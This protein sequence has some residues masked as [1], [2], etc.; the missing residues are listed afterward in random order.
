ME[1]VTLDHA[2]IELE[3]QFA[4]YKD[5]S[6]RRIALQERISRAEDQR[7][8][9]KDK[10]FQ[11]VLRGY[12]NDLQAVEQDL[13]PLQKK[14][15]EARADLK[16]R[17]TDI[18]LQTADL[19]DQLDELA[20]RHRVGEFD[21]VE[22][23]EKQAP[24]EAEYEELTQRGIDYVQMLEKLETL[25]EKKPLPADENEAP[26]DVDTSSPKEDPAAPEDTDTSSP[27][28]ESAAP[29]NTEFTSVAF[30]AAETT[31]TEVA[32]VNPGAPPAL[33]D[34]PASSTS[35]TIEIEHNT[36]GEPLV[37]PSTWAGELADE[38]FLRA[39]ESKGADVE[40]KTEEE[41]P[42]KTAEQATPDILGYTELD[43][44]EDSDASDPLSQLADPS[45]DETQRP[46]E[47]DSLLETDQLE[48]SGTTGQPGDGFPVLS[49]ISGAGAGK[50]LPLLPMTM[51]IGRELDNNIELKDQDVARYHAR[52]TYHAGEYV[53]HDLEGS[54]GTFVNGEKTSKTTL[55]PGDTLRVGDTELKFNLE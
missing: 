24:L 34:D 52:I 43:M 2:A 55:S 33:E 49:I 3:T 16:R 22:L 5:L 41:T 17:I 54:S 51:T 29:E 44:A 45:D 21:H 27:T 9:V 15:D 47:E 14:I 23:D 7:P 1:N 40:Q 42:E 8:S 20:F 37:D 11:R 18:D 46:Q 50:K 13:A 32:A 31:A 12:K 25:A 30:P 36:E 53:I 35:E 6:T 19:Q 38:A 4:Q 26:E 28:E 48:A 10:I 39:P